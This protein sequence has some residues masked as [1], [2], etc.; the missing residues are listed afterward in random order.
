MPSAEIGATNVAGALTSNK[1]GTLAGPCRVTNYTLRGVY[2]SRSSLY[3]R[4]IGLALLVVGFAGCRDAVSA[5]TVA[6]HGLAP[7]PDAPPLAAAVTRDIQP[8]G[9]GMDVQDDPNP[10]PRTR[11]RMEYHREN[12][13]R[14]SQDVYFIWY[15][16]WANAVADQA[17]LTDLA[18]SIGNTPYLNIVRLYPDSSGTPATSSVIYGGSVTDYYSHGGV[19]SD[20][21]IGDIVA[22]QLTSYALPPDPDGIF[23]V[24][25]SPDVIA[26]SGQDVSYCALHGMSIIMG[27]RTRYIY[28]G[29][30]SRSTRCS[31]QAIGPNG[32][33]DGDGMAYLFTAELA[34]TLTDP[35]LVTWYD[36]LGLEVADKCAWTFGTTY[37]ASNGAAANV[38]LGVRDY[39]LPQ[40]WVPSKNGGACALHW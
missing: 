32:T 24:F 30:P 34:N 4:S 1:H 2:M 27:Q 9:K 35:L 40:L 15:G 21:D 26:S 29:A 22:R 8:T 5:P 25:A 11:Y 18:S 16:G 13:L 28:V 31:P 19:L 3:R 38:H 33:I 17:V 37:R 36:R 39:L 7:R 12:V 10:P 6:T 23:V 14:G 20:A